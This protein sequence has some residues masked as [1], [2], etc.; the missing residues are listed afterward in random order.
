[1]AHL[2]RSE[3]RLKL[4][5]TVYRSRP[6]PPRWP[7]PCPLGLRLGLEM[8]GNGGCLGSLNDALIVSQVRIPSEPFTM[9]RH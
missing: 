4:E 2:V 5:H 6:P 7:V 9:R 1:M 3:V 8:V